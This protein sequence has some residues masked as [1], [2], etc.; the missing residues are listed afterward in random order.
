M[1]SLSRLAAAAVGCLVLIAAGPSAAQS[2]AAAPAPAEPLSVDDFFSS[3][4]FAGAKLSPSGRYVAMVQSNDTHRLIAVHDVQTDEIKSI[5]SVGVKDGYY[6]DWLAWKGDDRLLVGTTILQIKWAGGRENGELRSFKFGRTVFSIDRDGKAST[7]LFKDAEGVSRRGRAFAAMLDPLPRDPDHVLMMAM[8]GGALSVWRAN[9]HNGEAD[10]V[11]AGNG[12]TVGWSVDSNG[13]VVVRVD[14]RGDSSRGWTRIYGRAPGATEW[15][16]IVKLRAKEFREV[17][18]FKILGPTETPGQIY[19]LVEPKSAADGETSAVHVY[20][21]KTKSMGEPLRRHPKYDIAN[22]VYDGNS[23]RMVGYCFVADVYQCDFQDKKLAANFRGLSNFFGGERD[24]MPVSFSDNGLH[25]LLHV[26]GADEPGAYYL[27]D[28]DKKNVR[29]LGSQFSKLPSERLSRMK[30]FSYKTRDGA[31]LGGYLTRPPGEPAGPLPLVV[32]PHGGPESRDQLGFHPWAQYFASRGYLVFQPNFRGSG[33]FGRSFAEAGYGQWGGRMQDDVTDGV[34]A[35]IASGQ[36]DPSRVCAVGA[37]YGG[38]VALWGAATRPELY[39]CAVSVAGVTD[40]QELMEW[41]RSTFGSDSSRYEYWVKSIGDPK[42]DQARLEARSPAR[43]A[44]Q[45]AAPVLLIHGDSDWAVPL[46][47]SRRMEKAL[48]K[49]GRSVS[50]VVL[51]GEGHTN[52]SEDN[53]KKVLR[54]IGAFLE[55]HLAA[56]EPRAKAAP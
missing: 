48:K 14:Q 31:E 46:D 16:E 44:A 49:A 41:E 4:D 36:V 18:E 19:V 11:E 15:S 25:W 2:P 43:A 51:K 21:F 28:W 53:Q 26:S 8:K 20:D 9:I 33:G 35:L 45:F 27:Y 54:E 23:F 1:F 3:P 12:D 56:A 39:K 37:S 30:P 40:L 7:V 5:M 55:K 24:I 6:F 34:E 42:T 10:L 52:W 13:A 29:A 47:Q 17:D 38:Y 32:M 22:I 50:L